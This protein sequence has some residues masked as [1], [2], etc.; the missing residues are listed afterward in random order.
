MEHWHFFIAILILL[1][2]LRPVHEFFTEDDANVLDRRIGRVEPK[3]AILKSIYESN[4][5]LDISNAIIGFDTRI[6]KITDIKIRTKLADLN[7]KLALLGTVQTNTTTLNPNTNSTRMPVSYTF[8]LPVGTW[9]VTANIV[10]ISADFYSSTAFD[11]QIGVAINPRP[12]NNVSGYDSIQGFDHIE[13]PRTVGKYSRFSV[14]AT[15]KVTDAT[16]NQTLSIYDGN[17]IAYITIISTR[18]G[19]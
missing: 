15:I 11:A 9:R 1:L 18:I 3:T 4:K 13:F 16:T 10:Y 19:F 7:T 8:K 6:K 5:I 2:L 17:G 12:Y 14:S